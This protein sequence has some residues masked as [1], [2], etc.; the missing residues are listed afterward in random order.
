MKVIKLRTF[1]TSEGDTTVPVKL[2]DLTK[3]QI[4]D[5]SQDLRVVMDNKVYTDWDTILIDIQNKPDD[6][7]IEILR[8]KPIMG[9]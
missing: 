7:E 9:G 6:S 2:P 3:E 4:F 1:P 5:N 8:F